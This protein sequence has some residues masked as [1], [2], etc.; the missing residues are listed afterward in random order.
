[1]APAVATVSGL[2][3]GLA[4]AAAVCALLGVASVAYLAFMVYQPAP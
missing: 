2:D 3:K 4:I 1:M